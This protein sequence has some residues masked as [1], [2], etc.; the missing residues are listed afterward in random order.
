VSDF[1]AQ[2]C[3]ATTKSGER[4]QRLRVLADGLCFYHSPL[5]AE[6][7]ASARSAGGQHTSKAHRALKLLP[8]RLQPIYTRLERVFTQL[9]DGKYDRQQAVAMATVAS[10][11]LKLV[12][13]GEL[14]ERMRAVE[15]RL[16]QQQAESQRWA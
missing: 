14:E 11:L 9:D 7:R 1:I 2:R 16:Q 15:Q 6:Q 8:A 5:A 4:C 13:A 12:Q 10:V 3:A